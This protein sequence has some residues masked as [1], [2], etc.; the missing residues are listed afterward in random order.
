M[1]FKAELP[2]HSDLAKTMIAFANDAGGDLYIGVA[3]EPRKVVG[4]DEDKLMAIEEKISNIIFDRCYPAILPEI[5]FIS[6]DNKHLIQVTVFRGSTPPYYLKDKGK[7]QGTF[8][9]V[10][11]T[12]RLADE[13]IIS[14]LERRKRNISFD[15]EVIPDKPVN[16]LNIDNFKTMFKEKTG[17]ELSDQALRKLDLVKDMQGAEYP[18]NALIL[19]SRRSFTKLALSLCKSRVRPVQRR[20]NRRFYRPEEYYYQYCYTSRRGVQLRASSYQQRGNR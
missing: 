8:I 16:D 3:D 10:G 14:E 18:T 17:E 19:F 20:Y 6:E 11:S 4:L 5:K 1:E 7:L 15:S 13:S 9:R 2:E 12:N